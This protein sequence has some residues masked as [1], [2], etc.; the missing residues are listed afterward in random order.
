MI[1]N[2]PTFRRD[3]LIEAMAEVAHDAFQSLARITIPVLV[4]GDDQDLY[5]PIKF[6]RETTNLIP[7]AT[8]KIY[9]GKGHNLSGDK[10]I[11]QD[12]IVWWAGLDELGD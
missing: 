12:I 7:G 8:L 4:M 3:V 10:V 6:F 2:T 11:S 5:F 9:S 1:D